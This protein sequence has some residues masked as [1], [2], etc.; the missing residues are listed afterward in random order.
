MSSTTKISP[1]PLI[2][3]FRP[4]A[5]EGHMYVSTEHYYANLATEEELLSYRTR[6]CESSQQMDPYLG[7]SESMKSIS[8]KIDTWMQRL[9]NRNPFVPMAYKS[10]FND[11]FVA[12]SVLEPGSPYV[13]T[14]G[15]EHFTVDE[16][17]TLRGEEG[18]ADYTIIVDPDFL[19]YSREIVTEITSATFFG[20]APELAKRKYS[21]NQNSPHAPPLSVIHFTAS[22]DTIIYHKMIHKGANSKFCGEGKD[23][24]YL[25][26]PE[27][28]ALLPGKSSTFTA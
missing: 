19:Q 7:S 4:G 14:N 6:L 12:I 20:L 18:V 27:G 8:Q 23:D 9:R 28:L 11:S 25:S 16:E 1:F 5:E 13:D 2:H 26:I 15:K 22:K 10:K 21:I 24:F 17:G 3:V